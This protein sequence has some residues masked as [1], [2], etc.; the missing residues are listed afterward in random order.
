MLRRRCDLVGRVRLRATYP[1]EIQG[2]ASETETSQ[3]LR[4]L[5]QHLLTVTDDKSVMASY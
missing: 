2:G 3:Y 5:Q 4:S 1:E